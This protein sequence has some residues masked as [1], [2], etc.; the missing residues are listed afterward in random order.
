MLREGEPQQPPCKVLVI[1]LFCFTAEAVCYVDR[2]NISIA[3]VA[4]SRDYGWDDAARSLVLSSFFI[5]YMTTQVIGGVLSRRYGGRIVLGVGVVVWSTFT[6]ATPFAASQSFAALIACRI[7]MGIGEGV[8][9]PSIHQLLGVWVPAEWRSIATAF[10]TSGQA[11]GTIAAMMSTPLAA[12]SWQSLFLGFGA[13]GLVWTATFAVASPKEGTSRVAGRSGDDGRGDQ[14]E[15]VELETVELED[16]GMEEEEEDDVIVDEEEEEEVGAKQ[17]SRTQWKVAGRMACHP[18]V[19][20]IF[21]AHFAHNYGYYVLLSWMP[22]Y[23]ISL[24]VSLASVGAFA[25][26]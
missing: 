11:V 24:G 21:I 4:M 14:Q 5:G 6:M 10:A 17:A 25:V 15:S 26:G 3:I 22:Q 23:F 19:W 2:T 1:V 12:R 13:L 9:M 16:Y 18:P 20:G 7:C 8:A